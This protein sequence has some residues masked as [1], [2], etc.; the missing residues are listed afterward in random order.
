MMRDYP[1]IVRSAI[2]DSVVP[3]EAQLLN[4]SSSE[5]D[6]ALHVLFESCDSDTACASA[7]PD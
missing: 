5:Q 4:Q 3:I 2:L 1:E 6:Q 7:Y